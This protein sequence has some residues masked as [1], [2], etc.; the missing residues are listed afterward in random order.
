MLIKSYDDDWY[1]SPVSVLEMDGK[2][3]QQ[4]PPSPPPPPPPPQQYITGTPPPQVDVL[5]ELVYVESHICD[6]GTKY[7]GELTEQV[8]PYP[9]PAPHRPCR[10]CSTPYSADPHPGR[11]L[12]TCSDTFLWRLRW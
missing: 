11:I 3:S 8:P 6:S 7:Y 10:P 4:Q 5:D 2:V 1:G 9:D 12:I